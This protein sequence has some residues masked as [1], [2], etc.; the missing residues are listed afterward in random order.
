MGS[1]QSK[2]D[3]FGI[4][5][6]A[7]SRRSTL[8]RAISGLSVRDLDMMKNANGVGPVFRAA[9]LNRVDLL[10]VLLEKGCRPRCCNNILVSALHIAIR[11]GYQDI[12]SQI[13]TAGGSD[14]TLSQD[15]EG[16]LPM[17]YVRLENCHRDV[18]LTLERPQAAE[19]FGQH[20]W[21]VSLLLPHVTSEEVTHLVRCNVRYPFRTTLAYVGVFCRLQS[22]AGENPF[23]IAAKTDNI[24]LMKTLLDSHLGASL[25]LDRA[26]LFVRPDLSFSLSNHV[27][28]DRKL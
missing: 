19:V 4:I 21:A 11:E 14:A 26:G 27:I 5:E 13:L 23:H 10:A 18:F 16:R 25:R 15:G 17:H 7:S 22:L 2:E 6:N 9:E 3:V 1:P 28:N 20:S 8:D 24:E 12:V